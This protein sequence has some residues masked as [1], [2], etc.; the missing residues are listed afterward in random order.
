MRREITGRDPLSV[1]GSTEGGGDTLRGC[2]PRGVIPTREV[3]PDTQGDPDKGEVISR[4]MRWY[5]Q[6]AKGDH[7]EG[8]P[9]R[10]GIP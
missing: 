7:M 5:H 4:H 8:S 10:G 2:R 3:D 6:N 1:E 9:E